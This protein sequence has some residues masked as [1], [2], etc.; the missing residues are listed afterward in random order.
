MLSFFMFFCSLYL[1]FSQKFHYLRVLLVIELITLSLFI[2]CCFLF[3][4]GVGVS[5]VSFCLVFIVFGV[6]EAANGLGLLV[7]RRRSNGLDR[8][9]ALFSLGF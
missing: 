3:G 7:G 5:S 8:L 4:S 1:I 2:L 9:K 6:Y